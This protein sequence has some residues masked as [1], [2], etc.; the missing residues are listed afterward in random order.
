MEEIKERSQLHQ[1]LKHY[2]ILRFPQRA[3]ALREFLEHVL[4]PDDDITHFQYSK[5]IRVNAV[6]RWS[7]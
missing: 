3:G 6:P 4:G 7:E 5:R 1:G 2:F